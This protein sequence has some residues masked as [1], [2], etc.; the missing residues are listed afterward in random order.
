MKLSAVVVGW[1][2]FAILLLKQVAVRRIE[3]LVLSQANPI[4]L[5]KLWKKKTFLKL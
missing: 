2:L 1:H 4:H 3:K 5:L